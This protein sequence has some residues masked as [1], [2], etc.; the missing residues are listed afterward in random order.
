[1]AV[2][3]GHPLLAQGALDSVQHS[4]FE[5]RSCG[6]EVTSERI[7]HTFKLDSTEYRSQ[8]PVTPNTNQGKKSYPQVIQSINHL[9]VIDEPIGTCDTE[10]FSVKKVRSAK[11]LYLWRCGVS[12]LIAHRDSL[13]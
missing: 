11:C 13:P 2:A 3:S 5:C 4:Q 7:V 1:V 6:E 9:T 10:I 12:T 8:T